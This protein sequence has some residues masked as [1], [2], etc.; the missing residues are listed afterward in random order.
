MEDQGGGEAQW[1]ADPQKMGWAIFWSFFSQTHLVTQISAKFLFSFDALQYQCDVMTCR[2]ARLFSLQH[3]K[4][5]K[6][7]QITINLQNGLIIYQM[8]VKYTK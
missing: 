8:A 2:V 6:I 5:G 7:Y 1:V 3:T 4:T